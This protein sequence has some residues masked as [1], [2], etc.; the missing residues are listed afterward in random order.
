MLLLYVDAVVV[1]GMKEMGRCLEMPEGKNR[2]I[3]CSAAIAYLHR[4]N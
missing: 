4:K 2:A 3:Q 1:T